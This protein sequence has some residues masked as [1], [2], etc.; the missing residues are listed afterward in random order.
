MRRTR[1]ASKALPSRS[2]RLS[3]YARPAR[4]KLTGI[5]M[6]PGRN[7]ARC[8]PELGPTRAPPRRALARILLTS[9]HRE[10]AGEL[11]SAFWSYQLPGLDGLMT[12]I[13]ES[14]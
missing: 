3:L 9:Q 14:G 7:R 11:V 13:R 8:R 12:F 10:H 5:P 1:V 2:R 4:V 6:S